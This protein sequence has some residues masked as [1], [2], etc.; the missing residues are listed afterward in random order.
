VV[1][2]KETNQKAIKALINENK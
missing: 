1:P 2:Q